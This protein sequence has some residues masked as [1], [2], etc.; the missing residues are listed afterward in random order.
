MKHL[1]L[2]VACCLSLMVSSLFAKDY[3]VKV[4]A[5]GNGDSWEQASIETFLTK[6]SPQFLRLFY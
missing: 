2:F 4:G 5:S 3:Y 1:N 6:L